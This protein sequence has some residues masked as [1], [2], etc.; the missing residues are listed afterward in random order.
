MP[1]RRNGGVVGAGQTL[2]EEEAW[3]KLVAFAERRLE[4]TAGDEA[5]ALEVLLGDDSGEIKT[6]KRDLWP[7][8]VRR[9]IAE[10]VEREAEQG[11]G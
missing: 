6:I 8:T 1:R 10:A 5:A 3:E 11:G 9:A 2:G 4:Q 7:A